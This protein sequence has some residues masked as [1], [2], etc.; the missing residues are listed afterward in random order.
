MYPVFLC[1]PLPSIW[2]HLCSKSHPVG[3]RGDISEVWSARKR[4]PLASPHGAWLGGALA[5]W[6]INCWVLEPDRVPL[7]RGLSYK[8]FDNVTFE[9]WKA[10]LPQA[11]LEAS[12]GV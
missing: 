1:V 2:S 10:T 12:D 4:L 3:F 11:L 6:Q 7:I 8:V 9:K 5:H